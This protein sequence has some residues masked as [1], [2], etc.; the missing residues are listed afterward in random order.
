[1]VANM[2]DTVHQRGAERGGVRRYLDT[3]TPEEYRPE[4]GEVD[5]TE[6]SLTG[7]ADLYGSDK[8]NIKHR[9]TPHYTRIV[10]DLGRHKPLSVVEVGV[11]CGAS[12]RMWANYLPNA[13]IEG[14]DIRS[15]C[16]SLCRDLQNVEITIADPRH[17][18]RHCVDLFIDDGS[19]IAE[20]I[21]G[22]FAHCQDWIAPGG[23]Y[24]IED[25]SCTY[26]PE[27]TAK[28]N[29]HFNQNLKNDRTLIL[30]LLDELTKAVDNRYG[31][32]EI[33]YYPQ[34]LVLRK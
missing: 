7:L 9:Y 29:K 27:Y 31:W 6:V 28:F 8:G 1:M 12:L 5:L 26:K 13:K 20:D 33:R 24:V 4:T 18:E 3:V 14:F 19:H 21:V 2:A 10:D 23:Y 15:E 32:S 17:V 25:L 22:T 11:A 34:M 16:A 30:A